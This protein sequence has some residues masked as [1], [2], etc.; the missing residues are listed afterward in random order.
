[1]GT[2]KNTETGKRP[3]VMLYF[4]MVEPI[5]PLR[6]AEKGRLLMAIVNYARDG[7]QPEFTGR[8]AL[9]WGYI[10]PKLD[11][12]ADVYENTVQKKKYA[13]FCKKRTALKLSKIP[14]Q[15]WL[16]LTAE[17]RKQLLTS[18]NTCIHMDTHDNT[19]YPTGK[20]KGDGE[21]DGKREGDG[22]ETRK[23]TRKE[24]GKL[25]S[26]YV[27]ADAEEKEDSGAA[28]ATENKKFLFKKLKSCL[29]LILF[30]LICSKY[31]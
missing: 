24:K 31:K 18:D 12:D 23:E 25:N 8:L 28:A 19:C 21:G 30:L 6:D 27:S 7:I 26:S 14:Y 17:E 5:L 4:D 1:M 13:A 2:Q 10:Q 3:G 20:R 16:D 29:R 9:A 15:Q 11:R 22:K